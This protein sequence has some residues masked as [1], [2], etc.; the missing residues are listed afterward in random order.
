VAFTRKLGEHSTVTTRYGL[1]A[2]SEVLRIEW[3]ID[4]HEPETLLKAVFPTS[5]AGKMARY[6]APFGSILRPQHPGEE[7]AEAMFEV[8]ASR[9]A[10]VSDDGEEEGLA[11][12]TE[13][14]YGFTA[15]EGTL[16]LSLLR[17]AKITR[18]D[19]NRA[20]RDFSY[21]HDH[22][23]LGRFTIRAAL[24]LH[25]ADLPRESQPAAIAEQLFQTPIP[26]AK[27]L[28][29]PFEFSLEGGP[30]LLPVWAQ[31]LEDG[32]CVI[33][34]AETMGRRGHADIRTADGNIVEIVDLMGNPMP[35][36][37]LQGMR[38]S[39]GPYQLFGIKISRP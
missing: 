1:E 34:C 30:S 33:R 4:W 3:D 8:P 14:K 13:A 18:T 35:S 19:Q 24:T 10:I 11:L 17:S 5:Y 37:A 38:I 32:N 22:S 2:E 26:I 29:K 12:I 28:N 36:P 7:R 39:F 16:G 23:D 31:P 15:R 21:P 25:R 27:E 6:G 20:L 9:W